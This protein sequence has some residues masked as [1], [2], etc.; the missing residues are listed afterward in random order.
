MAR[1]RSSLRSA[2]KGGRLVQL[3]WAFV[4]PALATA[5]CY[6]M[7]ERF[8]L[9]DLVMVYLLGV[10]LVATRSSL[11]PSILTAIL[12]ALAFEFFFI[13]PRLTFAILDARH[14][15]TF[16]LML[17][18]AIVITGLTEQARRQAEAAH[19]AEA[20]AATERLRSSLLSAV[21]H[22]LRTPL[23]AITGAA[24]TM[25]ED[26]TSIEPS[27]RRDLTQT[28]FE[29]AERLHRLL[30]NLLHM[31]R[32]ESGPVAIHKDWQPVEEVIGA[33]LTRLEPRLRERA[34][35]THLP[36]NVTFAPFDAVLIEQVLINLLENAIRYTPA[37]SPIDI[38]VLAGEAEVMVEVADRGP[39][40]PKDQREDVFE[41]FHRG[42]PGAADGGVGLGLS[43][44]RAIIGAHGG[45]I[46]V[47]QREGGGATF[48][49]SL[50]THGQAPYLAEGSLPEVDAAQGQDS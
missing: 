32:L 46:G 24:S 41:K 44:C 17:L 36:E 50:P 19:R 38:S 8:A 15:V 49:F 7:Y 47:D 20:E 28:I 37:E 35:H 34:V 16:A 2:P 14:L 1:P 9:A 18:V 48:R 45:T 13:P 21:S 12:S 25:L 30:T 40:V 4:V 3:G 22:D 27:V 29:E 26:D 43:I 33:A 42:A 10:V 6:A 23:A 39:G 31:T 5:V 11:S